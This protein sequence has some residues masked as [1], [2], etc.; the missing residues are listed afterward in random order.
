VPERPVDGPSLVAAADLVVSAGGT[1]NRE[2]AAL[3]VPAWTPFAARLGAVDRRLIEEGRLRRLETPEDVVL[4][5]RNRVDPPPLRDPETL[6]E[7]M[8]AP[9]R[10]RVAAP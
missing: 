5:R 9:A 4:E 7:L 3:G 10:G 6:L 2:A 1:M 8:L